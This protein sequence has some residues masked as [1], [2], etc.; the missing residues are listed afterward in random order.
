MQEQLEAVWPGACL[1]EIGGQQGM[2]EPQNE[3]D[4]S[5]GGLWVSEEVGPTGRSGLKW[6]V[7]AALMQS[8]L[9][10]CPRVRLV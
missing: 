3:S 2:P 10:I 5:G 8:C 6:N 9:P 1:A 7:T 4:A